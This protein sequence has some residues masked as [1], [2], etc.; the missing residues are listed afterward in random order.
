MKPHPE[1]GFY[2]ETF[3]SSGIIAKSGLPQNFNGDRSFFT[4][5][6]FLL[7]E[8]K[9]S[10][11]HRLKSDEAWHFYLGGPLTLIQISP[12]GHLQTIVLGNDLAAGHQ[13]Q[14][15]V[16][17]GYWFGAYPNVGSE[18]SLVGCTVAPGFDFSDFEMA[19]RKTLLQTFP[20]LSTIVQQL[21]H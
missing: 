17:A 1:G 2:R 19:D 4:A 12:E 5:I 9:N 8:G 14:H 13:L 21:T 16:P 11:L 10:K 7:S 15:V 3:R 6:Y 20:H 18:F